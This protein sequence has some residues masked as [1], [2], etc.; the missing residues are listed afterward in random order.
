MY[1]NS[2]HLLFEVIT[3]DKIVKIK[4]YAWPLLQRAKDFLASCSY[5]DFVIMGVIVLIPILA[6]ILAIASRKNKGGRRRQQNTVYIDRPVYVRKSRY[7]R[8]YFKPRKRRVRYIKTNAPKVMKQR[9]KQRAKQKRLY[10]KMDQTTLLATG[11]FGASLGMM[12]HK[13]ALEEKKK[14]YF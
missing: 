6:V 11:L 14:F 7:E 12:A 5:V 2:T 8:N 9:A 1:N 13:A 3:V 4:Q 10:C